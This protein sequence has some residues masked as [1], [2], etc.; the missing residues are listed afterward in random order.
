MPVTSQ[1][2]I[3]SGGSSSVAPGPKI[4]YGAGVPTAGVGADGDSYID[5]SNPLV[6]VLY[7]P[8]AAGAWPAVGVP[9]GSAAVATETEELGTWGVLSVGPVPGRVTAVTARALTKLTV[10]VAIAPSGADLTGVLSVNGVVAG[11][12]AFTIADG[13]TESGVITLALPIAL[14]IS[15]IVSVSITQV[16]SAV[17]GIDLFVVL[18]TVAL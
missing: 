2:V 9:L 18:Y 16:G 8:K 13:A 1:T 14:A 7:G 15:D 11:T 4:V 10:S 17:P 12:T 3:G 6:P 5:N